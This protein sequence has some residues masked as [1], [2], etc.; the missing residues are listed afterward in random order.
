VLEPGIRV[1]VAMGTNRNLDSGKWISVS[2]S[3][4]YKVLKLGWVGFPSLSRDFCEEK[5][6]EIIYDF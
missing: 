2:F 3:L 5:S 1:T 6:R 4:C